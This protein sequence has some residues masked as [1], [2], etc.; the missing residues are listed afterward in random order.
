MARNKRTGRPRVTEPTR[1]EFP[2][3]VDIQQKDHMPMVA[4]QTPPVGVVRG[5]APIFT[6]RDRSKALNPE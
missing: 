6:N 4:T 1:G 2:Q 5:T 3:L